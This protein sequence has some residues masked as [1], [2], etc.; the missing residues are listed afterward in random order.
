MCWSERVAAATER[1]GGNLTFFAD[2]LYQIFPTSAAFFTGSR[3]VK[4]WEN[5]MSEQI[6]A[7][8]VA[9]LAQS[10]YLTFI[11]LA[12]ID[13][14]RGELEMLNPELNVVVWAGMSQEAIEAVVTLLAA[15]VIVFESVDREV[16]GDAADAPVYPVAQKRRHYANTRWLP[17]A[18]D[19]GERFEQAGMELFQPVD[20]E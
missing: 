3:R 13:G 16:Y 9:M 15:E 4:E 17:V 10:E 1:V 7:A 20:S 19:R 11:E 5:S 18:I 8:I 12:A 2:S 6:Q 14:F